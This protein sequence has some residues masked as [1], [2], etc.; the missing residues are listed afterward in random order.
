MN[1]VIGNDNQIEKEK[2]PEKNRELDYVNPYPRRLTNFANTLIKTKPKNDLQNNYYNLNYIYTRNKNPFNS[3]FSLSNI[4]NNIPY[5]E[6]SAYFI[7][8]HRYLPY[9]LI[10]DDNQIIREILKKKISDIKEEYT[11]EL[12]IV[13]GND[14]MDV[15][16]H[17]IANQNEG[18]LRCVFTDENMKYINGSDAIKLIRN[19]EDNNKI[20]KNIII[21][22]TAYED[23]NSINL[24]TRAGADFIISKPYSK[25]QI[26]TVLTK[27]GIIK[28][29]N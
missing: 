27:Y 18:F 2:E 19:L 1:S 25:N 17:I 13:E 29:E 11:I 4:L 10:V 3:E 21:S 12:N 20:N 24:I 9:I 8:Y 7:E 23:E 26:I 14:G 22:M 16:N 6:K 28:L 15:L 5:L